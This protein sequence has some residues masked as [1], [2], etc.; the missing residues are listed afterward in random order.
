MAILLVKGGGG[1]KAYSHLSSYDFNCL[2][3]ENEGGKD[4]LQL[5]VVK[6]GEN[7]SPTLTNNVVI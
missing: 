2:L 7:P 5:S 4:F 3:A 1:R 6:S